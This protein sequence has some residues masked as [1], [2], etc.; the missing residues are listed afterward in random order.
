MLTSNLWT[1]VGLHNGANGT[2]VDLVY[3]NS[4]GLRNGGVPESV[5]VKFWDLAENTYI[6]SFLEGCE[7]SLTIPMK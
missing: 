2:V 5:V 6:E 1:E 4:E 7:Q 3:T